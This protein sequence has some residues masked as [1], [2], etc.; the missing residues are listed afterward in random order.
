MASD[1]TA[2]E[3]Y[4][5]HRPK[6][7]KDVI[8]QESAK[9]MLVGMKDAL[10]HAILFTGPSGTGK[11]TMARIL[12]DKLKCSD[13][14][15]QEV[16]AAD[17]RGIDTVR[18]IRSQMSAAPLGGPCR[19]WL[20]DEVQ[21]L[22]GDAQSSLLKMLEDTPSH[23]YFMLCTTNPEKLKKTIITRCTEI[24]CTILTEDQLKELVRKV[25]AAENATLSDAV[26]NRIADAA[27]GSGRKA[28]V[29]LHAVIRL[30]SQNE[31]LA[32]ISIADTKNQ[33][34]EIARKLLDGNCNWEQMANILRG[35][36]DDAEA[37]RRV[38]LGYC[39]SVLLNSNSAGKAGRVAMI[40]EEF[41]E[42]FYTN[43]AP[44]LVLACYNVIAAK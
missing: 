11:T 16:N 37:V 2:A 35:L 43:G 36:E 5:R 23:V 25:V 20:L 7:F 38:V 30:P 44:D 19:V 9:K 42:P 21:S 14:D 33:S 28:L 3:F 29:L 27:D 8:G 40:M 15:F 39:K 22:T 17:F 4:R 31:Q 24:K 26:V 1:D 12:R 32:A 41:R 10:P 13:H 6:N 34:I 18:E